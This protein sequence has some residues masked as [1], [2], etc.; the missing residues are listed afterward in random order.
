M[1]GRWLEESFLFFEGAIMVDVESTSA[2]QAS[3][4]C[5]TGCEAGRVACANERQKQEG[6]RGNNDKHRKIIRYSTSENEQADAGGC[7]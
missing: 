3:N 7:Y 5:N 4:T 1:A 6:K 2:T